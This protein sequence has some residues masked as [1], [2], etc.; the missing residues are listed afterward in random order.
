M[1][2]VFPEL[3][4]PVYDLN[5]EYFSKMSPQGHRLTKKELCFYGDNHFLAGWVFKKT[6]AGIEF[7][8][9]F[10]LDKFI[11]FS[12]P[13]IAIK[14]ED[15]YFKW[16][17]VE[18][19]GF[20]CLKDEN[21]TI[22]HF[23]GEAITTYFIEQ[24]GS[25]I[26]EC[27]SGSNKNDFITEFMSYWNRWCDRKRRHSQKILMLADP[28][29]HSRHIH[30]LTF[31]NFILICDAIKDGI[32]WCELFLKNRKVK[33]KDFSLGSYIWLSNPIVPEQYPSSNFSAANLVKN[34]NNEDWEILKTAVPDDD[35]SSIIVFGFES[36]NGPAFGGI[37]LNEPALY[38]RPGKKRLTREKGFRKKGKFSS[39]AAEKYFSA[40]GKAN[41][42]PVQRIDREW[43]FDRGSSGLNTDFNRSYIGIIGC[44]S[45]GAQVA[46]LLI[47]SGVKRLF[48]IDPDKL[49]WDN[50][51]RHLLG[52]QYTSRNKAKAMEEYFHENYPGLLNISSMSISW[53]TA[54]SKHKEALLECDLIISTC[55][56]WDA[57]A[58]L[59]FAFN[60][61]DNFPSVIYGWTEPF[62]IV[63]HALFTSNV[64]GCL[65]CGMDEY[66]V[67]SHRVT[68]WTPDIINKRAPACGQTYQPYGALEIA[69]TQSMIARLALDVISKK[70]TRSQHRIWLGGSSEISTMDGNFSDWAKEEGVSSAAD[71]QVI[72][73]DWK[74][75]SS[76]HFNH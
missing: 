34:N 21:D 5:K 76:C 38:I 8:L 45:V 23:S 19:K 48:F 52:A 53:Q 35:G 11:P 39:L 60:T 75:N 56:D 67:F 51:A 46:R 26:K 63:G 47:E 9:V 3:A 13:K 69:N 54:L 20:L 43:I 37:R 6:I 41:S 17:H 42:L 49:S 16:P 31:Q 12:S 14:S 68:E 64:G 36:G 44:G 1:D 58:S 10:L 32:Q 33:E 50:I 4:G 29:P 30:T 18:E 15:Y 59:N 24:A 62:G 55:G 65:S 71:N 73:H 72:I 28:I 66:G 2:W 57:E 70:V 7:T 25:L 74:I 61:I 40:E 22:S 27:L